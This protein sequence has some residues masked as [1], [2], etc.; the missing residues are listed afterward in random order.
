M[1]TYK[2]YVPVC[3]INFISVVK[4]CLYSGC[5]NYLIHCKNLVIQFQNFRIWTKYGKYKNIKNIETRLNIEKLQKSK[6]S[7]KFIFK[8]IQ[9]LVVCLFTFV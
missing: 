5:Q 3:N 6:K 2:L 8:I 9:Y 7:N 4:F 1:A